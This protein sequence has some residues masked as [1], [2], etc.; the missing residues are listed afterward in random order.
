MTA[1][2]LRL[3]LS[4]VITSCG[5]TS[6]VTVR[7]SIFTIRSSIGTIQLSPARFTS[8]KR[9]RRKIT[10]ASYSWMILRPVMIQRPMGMRKMSKA[11]GKGCS[12]RK[13]RRRSGGA[14]G[15]NLEHQAF[16]LQHARP[17]TQGERVPA[18][19]AP[20][21]AIDEHAAGGPYGDRIA[22][23]AHLP[24][25]PGGARGEAVARGAVHLRHQR[26]ADQQ[27]GSP[28]RDHDAPADAVVAVGEPSGA[29]VADEEQRS[30]D[31]AE[32]PGHDEAA[33]A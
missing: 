24:H 5:G 29:D 4:R 3:T 9:P 26:E 22:D 17:G 28:H 2:T 15:G 12:F 33:V 19:R 6:R 14:V 31:H 7:R 30:D 21:L 1:L 16:D 18:A 32:G 27:Q 20:Q 25:Q 23:L 13:R 10:P 8:A 11:T